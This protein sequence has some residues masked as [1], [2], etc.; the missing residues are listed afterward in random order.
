MSNKIVFMGTPLFAVPILKKLH[1]NGYNISAVYTQQ[2]KKSDRGQ[3]INKTPV[4]KMAESLNLKVRTPNNL[5]DNENEIKFLKGLDADIALVVAYGKII[6]KKF[7]NLPK[8][9]FINIHASI[10]PKWRGAAPIQ[11][12]IM[13]L[14][15]ETGISIMRINEKLDAGPVS[16]VYKLKIDRQDNYED[17]S[18]SLSLLAANKIIENLEKILVD[19]IAFKEQDH[20]NA[21][22]AKKVLKS[23]GKIDWK[24]SAEIILGKIKGLYPNPGAWFNFEGRRHKILDAKISERTGIPG[25]VLDDKLT[26]GCQNKSL[27][28]TKIQKEGKLPQNLD[29]FILGSKIRKGTKLN[30]L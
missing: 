8:K 29:K 5:E 17:I 12:S 11:R 23:E 9:G 2:A 30:D 1:Q 4:Q 25:V 6:P 19:N 7:L 26:I 20:T 24:Y 16:K 22:Y 15:K 3:N 13:N 28:I 10:L 14:D 21:T 27:Q 18:E